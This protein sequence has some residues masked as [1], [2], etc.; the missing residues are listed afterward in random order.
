MCPLSCPLYICATMELLSAEQLTERYEAAIKPITQLLDSLTVQENQLFSYKMANLTFL[1]PSIKNIALNS[2]E[3][4]DVQLTEKHLKEIQSVLNYEAS[5]GFPYLYSQATISLYTNLE[6]AI[7]D[8]VQNFFWYETILK[9]IKQFQVV[10]ISYND[11]IKLTSE[12]RIFFLFDFYEN[13][14]AA[15]L[16][17]GIERFESLL[18]PIGLS[19]EIDKS[20]SNAIY[21]LGQ[22]R[23]NLVHNNGVVD[24]RLIEACPWLNLKI[25]ERNSINVD[26]FE[27]YRTNV[28][29]YLMVVAKRVHN[30]DF[31]SL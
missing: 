25:G 5:N 23:N 27:N 19:G 26:K 6:A 20:I 29:E 30:I 31:S 1:D 21:E 9:Q 18:R 22:V 17:Y 13:S 14:V 11:F 28:M 16:K 7:R 3:D 4:S 2:K 15:G 8:L 24:K 10:K 12:E